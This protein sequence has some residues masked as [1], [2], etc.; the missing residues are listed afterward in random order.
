MRLDAGG[1][2]GN[3]RVYVT[4]EQSADERGH[5]L[6]M[7]LRGAYLH[8]RRRSNLA[9]ARF[10][11]SADQYVLLTVLA[12]A[13]EATQQELVKRCYSDTATIGAMV[14]LLEGKGLLT[15]S[16]HPRDRRARRVRLTRPGQR[17]AARM[18]RCSA[19]VRAQLVS[20]FDAQELRTLAGLLDR[21][22]AAMRPSSSR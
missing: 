3:C 21:L 2:W 14:A 4:T 15:R 6:A 10:G 9:F 12:H 1:G 13:G 17:L 20:L 16:P 5:E 11:M 22:G 19:D 7:H 8:L 18:R